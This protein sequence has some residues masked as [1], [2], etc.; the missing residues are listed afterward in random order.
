MKYTEGLIKRD[1]EL[2]AWKVMIG[3]DEDEDHPTRA[4]Q[5]T[6][7]ESMADTVAF[8]TSTNPDIMYLYEAMKASYCDEFKK[9]MDKELKDH[10]KKALASDQVNLKN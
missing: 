5:Y 9:V 1:Q 7:Q 2:L 6:I 3:Q 8:T 4:E 10:I